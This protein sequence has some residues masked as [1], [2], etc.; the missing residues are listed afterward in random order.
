MDLLNRDYKKVAEIHF[1]AGLVPQR[2]ASK[3]EFAQVFK[4]DW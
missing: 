4:I 1:V 2:N 3:D